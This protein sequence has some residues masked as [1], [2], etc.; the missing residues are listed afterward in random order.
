MAASL[1]FYAY[2]EETPTP[3][4]TPFETPTPGKTPFETPGVTS[5]TETPTPGETPFFT[6]DENKTRTYTWDRAVAKAN[7]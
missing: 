1:T 3:G 4:V 7:F 6:S 5:C 2:P